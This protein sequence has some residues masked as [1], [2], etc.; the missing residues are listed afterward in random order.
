MLEIVQ[1]AG[2]WA[3][4][5]DDSLVTSIPAF[6]DL[7]YDSREFER[8]IAAFQADPVGTLNRDGIVARIPSPLSRTPPSQEPSR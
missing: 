5:S 3:R 1:I 4:L 7:A 6:C 8:R 2:R